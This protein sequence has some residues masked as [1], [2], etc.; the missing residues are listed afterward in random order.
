VT[1]APLSV[2]CARLDSSQ[3]SEDSPRET[4]W[5]LADPRSQANLTGLV[6]VASSIANDTAGQALLAQLAVGNKTVFAPSNDALSALPQN[7]TSNTTLLVET[8]AYHIL[9]N[10]YTVNGTKVLPNHTI[11]RTLLKGDGYSLPGNF[12]APVVLARNSSNATNFE[13]VQFD[14]NITAT[15]PAMAAN[16]LVY[17]VDQVLS[18][19]PSIAT[20]ATSLFPTLAGVIQQAGLLD[21]LA[22]AQGITVFA[23]SDAVLSGA[24]SALGSLNST[25]LTDL[26]ANHVINGESRLTP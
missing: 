9:N 24:Q 5:T 18:L 19:P 13:I 4:V 16:L 21:P 1:A 6:S 15:G 12:S 20:L 7:V 3:P 26:L 25:Q 17:V 10:T 14:A 23:P 8:L 2:V 11:A 22:S